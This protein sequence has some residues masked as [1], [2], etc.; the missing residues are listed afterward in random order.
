MERT[1]RT[2]GAAAVRQELGYDGTGVGVAVID[3]GVTPWHD[4]LADAGGG[5]RV[6]RFVDFVGG[7]Q[8]PRD[9]YGHGT[10]VAGIVAGNGFDSD[11]ARTGIAP[12]AHL[13]VLRC[14]TARAAATSAT[15]SRRS[16]TWSPTRRRLNIRVVNLSMAGRRVRVVQHGS[17][18][19]CGAARGGGRDRR[20]RGGREQRPRRERAHAVRRHHGAGQRAVGADRRRV[21]PHGHRRSRRRHDRGVQ[22]AR[23]D[24]DR[25][26]RRSRTSSRRASASSRSANPGSSLYSTGVGVPA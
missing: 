2:I 13:V 7:S 21:E 15:S 1:G 25:L 18:D 26:S 23:T 5:Q 6:V 3:S 12:G 16:T 8:T 24:G 17:P 4:D 19:A 20:R 10:H 9:D 11:G 14:S 22:L